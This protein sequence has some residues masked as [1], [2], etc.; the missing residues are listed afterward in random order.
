MH[1]NVVCFSLCLLKD[2]QKMVFIIKLLKRLLLFIVLPICVW[3]VILMWQISTY[4]TIST[5]NAKTAIVLGAAVQD[6]KPSPV[7]RERINHAINLYRK[8]R[9]RKIIFTGGTGQGDSIAESEVARR[10]AIKNGIKSK[11]I[12]T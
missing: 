1:Q 4:S 9:I 2:L 12:L 3:V 5:S 10:Y 7:F 11:D 8:G 6:A